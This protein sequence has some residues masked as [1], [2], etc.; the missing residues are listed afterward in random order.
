MSE[1]KDQG[2]GLPKT[3]QVTLQDDGEKDSGAVL[4]IPRPNPDD[5]MTSRKLM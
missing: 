5:D 4:I 2:E 3:V 1:K